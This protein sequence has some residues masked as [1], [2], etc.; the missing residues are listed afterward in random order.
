MDTVQRAKMALWKRFR[1][2]TGYPHDP[3]GYVG[4]P[5]RNLIQGV[6]PEMIKEDY[7]QG[8]GSEWNTKFRAIH[9]SA[10]LAANSF[11]RWKTDPAALA[12]QGLSGFGPPALEAKCPTGLKGTPPNLDVLLQSSTDV[13][14]IESKLLEPLTQKKSKFSASYTRTNLPRCEEQWWALLEDTKRRSPGYFD[15]A[16]II[17]HY[18]GLR[19]SFQDGRRIHL[20]YIYWKPLNARD[21][22][23]YESH[24]Q[25]IQR[26]TSFVAGSEVDFV[27]MDYLALWRHWRDE[28]L[29]TPHVRNLMTRYA[30]EI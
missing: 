29:L 10:A 27:A 6:S 26:F 4:H 18:L 21:F 1:E 9:S 20:L 2:V 30:V 5:A 12:I 16:Q 19:N 23:E 25:E 24:Q 11:G 3:D 15:A 17:K 14:G 8:S 13:I 28:T 7:L 22:P